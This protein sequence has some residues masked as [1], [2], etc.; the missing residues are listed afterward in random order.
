MRVAVLSD[1]HLGFGEGTERAGESFEQARQA[2]EL[3]LESKADVILLAGDIFDSDVPSQET[4][5]RAFKLFS[6]V[7]GAKSD[8]AVVR[9]KG[10][11][12]QDFHFSHVPVIAIHGTH[13]FRGRGL[14]NAVE[15]L[16]SAGIL[17]HLH[18]ATA[19][20]GEIAV[21]GLS[22]VPEKKALDALRLW[23]PRPLPG[24]KNILMLH[25]SIKDFL[26]FEDDMI[27]S[28]ALADLPA[29]FDLIA[30][31]HLHWRS[32]EQLGKSALAIPGST[33]ITQMKRLEAEKKK[34]IFLWDSGAGKLEFKELRDQREFFYRKLDFRDAGQEEIRA[35]IESEL[36]GI[37]SAL[38]TS[39]GQK[40]LVKIKLKGA[41]ARGV[42]QGDLSFR[43]ILEKFGERAI[44]S[45]DKGFE[46]ASFA[47]RLDEL[48]EDQKSKR[49]IAALGLELLEKNL[50][51]TSFGKAFDVR[52]F[53][54]LLAAGNTDR[55]V[56]LLSKREK[57]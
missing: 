45:I 24:K 40:P 34:G 38:S 10:E 6:I 49:S 12:R 36:E 15:V 41:L 33:I 48:R 13:E 2:L 57:D 14:K 35:A 19:I 55:V 53:F 11:S 32:S 7:R 37:L 9:E 31:G 56:E 20:V 50:S 18:A 21:H 1:F 44:I 27:A 26:P 28:I 43:G 4:W 8:L 23:N 51:Q 42:Q 3:A 54:E 16:E 5:D 46:A 39:A 25:Q 17:V 29:G 22:G 52:E 47:R 30:N